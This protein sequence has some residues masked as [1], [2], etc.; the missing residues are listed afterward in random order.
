MRLGV[1]VELGEGPEACVDKVARLGLPTCQVACQADVELS[2][3]VAARLRRA[4]AAHGVAITAVWAHC[5]RGQVWSFD[6]GPLT[7]GVVPEATRAEAVARLEAASYFAR[8]AGVD[9]LATH[10][11]YIPEHPS[12]P[13]YPGVVGALRRVAE[14]CRR[15]GQWFL[16]ETGQETP[17]TLLRAIED[18]GLDNVGVNL[19]PANLVMG[20]KGHPLDAL[21]LFGG[22]VRGVHAKDGT[23]PTGGRQRGVQTRLGE[24]QVD[25]RA[26]IARLKALGYDGALTIEY[27]VSG[28]EQTAGIEQAKRL[29]A[30]LL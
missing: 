6:Q 29:L 28:P 4:A 20:G 15:N 24:G 19:D 25:F 30:P 5:H 26:L 12:D 11:G 22:R 1:V 10:A 27:E 18:V 9:A 17:M 21:D 14:R 23:H 13:V 8:A 16:L 7:I 3:A 2:D